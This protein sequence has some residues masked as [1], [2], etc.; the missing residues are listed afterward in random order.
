MTAKQQRVKETEK[1]LKQAKKKHVENKPVSTGAPP[2][3]KGRETGPKHPGHD[4]VNPD[5]D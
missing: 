3:P 5:P 2:D 4:V 1:T